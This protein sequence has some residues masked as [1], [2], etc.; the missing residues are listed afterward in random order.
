MGQQLVTDIVINLAGNLSNKARQYG[1][2]MNQFAANNQR[3]MNMLKMSASVVGRGID[4]IGNRYVALGAAVV[5]GSAVR[6]YSQLDRRISRIA[7]A[8]DISREKSKDL[9]EEI[10]R[11]S[12][13]KGIR[14]D[15][16]EATA[17]IEEILTKTGDLDY[18]MANLP[19]IATV[20]QATGAGG[21]EVGGIFTEFKKLAIESN[22]VAMRAIDTLNL[23]GKQGAFTLGNMAKEGP[24]IFAAYAATGRQG[25]D[26]VTELGA[27]LQ[28]IRQG[29]G[30]DTEAVTAFESLIRDITRPDT[31]KSLKQLG[32]IDVFDPEQ[33]KQGKEV[34]R[35]LPVLMEE[36]VTKSKGLS[37]NLAALNLTDEAK[38]ALKP[39]IA[40]FVQSGD[41][42]AFDEFLKVAGDGTTTMNDAAVASADFAASIQLISNSWSQFSNQQLAAPIAE[43]ADAINSL[44]PDAVQNWLETGKNIALVVGGLVAV[45]KGVDAARWTKG[46]WDAAKPGKKGGG[47]G[48]AMG[49]LGATP[50]Y[51]VNMPGGGLDLT[52]GGVPP[53]GSWKMPKWLMWGLRGGLI[54]AEAAM[55]AEMAPDF[56]PVKINRT[57]GQTLGDTAIPTAPGFLDAWDE[58][59]AF[60]ATNNQ[61]AARPEKSA[62]DIYLHSDG[63]V[64]A[65]AKPRGIYQGLNINVD[66]GPSL[67]P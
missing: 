11:V 61:Q 20:I 35:S 13:L 27:A 65:T 9:Y 45:K 17:A 16:S 52:P 48:G 58:I 4:S 53:G 47:L 59:S 40:E 57:K 8:A 66:T 51:V 56:S 33:L 2:S 21:T 60:F 5:G 37:T 29:V 34:M 49:A 67:M 22:D 6:G 12:N 7:I 26:A 23:Q 42:K 1:Q 19:N 55:I 64:G 24:K 25:A 36:I 46:V 14:I 10:Q 62:L 39:V 63:P 30:S 32:N 41:I 43:L 3:A 15:P 18:A 31:V 28:I 50:V 54:T 44:D 38:R